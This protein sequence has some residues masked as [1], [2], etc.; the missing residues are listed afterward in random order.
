[1][2]VSGAY[3][4]LRVRHKSEP[5]VFSIL[6][7]KGQEEGEDGKRCSENWTQIQGIHSPSERPLYLLAE[8]SMLG[9]SDFSKPKAVS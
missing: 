3:E 1:M 5:V 7:V 2:F 8:S 4:T 9:S 6:V